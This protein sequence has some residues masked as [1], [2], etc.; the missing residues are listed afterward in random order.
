METLDYLYKNKKKLRDDLKI[1]FRNK[2]DKALKKEK[3]FYPEDRI[4]IKKIIE[5]IIIELDINTT[6]N[7]QN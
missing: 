7:S 3:I 1:N 6:K 5:K 4:L 2:M